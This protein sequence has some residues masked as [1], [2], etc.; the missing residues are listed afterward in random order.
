[1]CPRSVAKADWCRKVTDQL[2]LLIGEI[3]NFKEKYAELSIGCGLW[4]IMCNGPLAEAGQDGG[5]IRL[6]KEVILRMHNI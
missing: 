1:M 2:C 5:A 4:C 3:L 6:H